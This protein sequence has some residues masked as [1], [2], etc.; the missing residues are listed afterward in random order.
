VSGYGE[1]LVCI[2]PFLDGNTSRSLDDLSRYVQSIDLWTY[3]AYSGMNQGE[4]WHHLVS[5]SRF[6]GRRA[7]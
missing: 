6:D 2:L 3:D 1:T 5:P 4:S 7:V